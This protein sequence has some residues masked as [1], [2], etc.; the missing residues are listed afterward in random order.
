MNAERTMISVVIIMIGI[1]AN[2][3]SDVI[4]DWLDNQIPN[5]QNDNDILVG[6][7]NLE[8]WLVIPIS[9]ENDNFNL[10]T[11]DSILNGP[12]SAST[13]I[14]QIS[15]SQS[16]LN[17]T[18]LDDVW[19]SSKEI[20]FWGAD[21]DVERDSGSDG[22]GV[23]DLVERVVKDMLIDKDL[24]SWDLDN[25]GVLDRIL[26]LHSAT[27]QE[28]GGGSDSIWSHMSGLDESVKVGKWSI[29]HYTIASTKSGMGT[30]VHEMLHQMGAYDLYDVHSSLPTSNWN[31]IGDWG[32]MASGNWNGNGDSPSFPSS[33]TLELIGINRSIIVDP[34]IGGNFS[35][36]PIS[37]SGFSLSIEIAPGEYIRITNRGDFGFDSS[38]PGFGILVEKQDINNGDI[39]TNLVNT[40]SKNAWLKIIEADGDDALIRNRDSGSSTDTFQDGDKFGNLNSSDGMLIYDNR[41]R[42]VTWFATISSSNDS[43]IMVNITPTMKINSFNVLTPRSPVELLNGET[44]FVEVS[45][46]VICNLTIEVLSHNNNF[47]NKTVNQLPTGLSLVPVMD[48]DENFPSNGALIGTI[49]CDEENNR[50]LDLEWHKVG[51]R[52]VTDNFYALIDYN[53][54]SII[55]LSPDYEGTNS[56][57]YNLEIQGAASRVAEIHNL[58]NNYFGPGDDLLITINPEG[59]LVPG[60]IARGE[61]VLVDDFG[62]E[63]RIPIT[64]EA[65]SSFNS[66]TALSWLS[67]PGNGLLMISIFLAISIFTGGKEK[68]Q[69]ITKSEIFDK[70]D[71]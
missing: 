42:L 66:N 71:L 54:E 5:E 25:N 26:L 53:K 50:T 46:D 19:I 20:G 4:D 36:K 15:D 43:A 70:S 18:I 10:A 49:G 40:D 28:I 69:K 3:N 57:Y 17:A 44:L 60:M 2:I 34:N 38:L 47:I 27:P 23:N 65:K 55:S 62:I 6:V 24:S 29:E 61:L 33:S 32:I 68:N 67:E 12:N 45:T 8:N 58:N 64:L 63:L 1:S 21:G 16:S 59:L 39:N 52:I 9:F 14:Q 11:A 30:L 13:Y 7:Q 51:N 31:G 35:L 37:D 48:I 56:R 41:G 22:F